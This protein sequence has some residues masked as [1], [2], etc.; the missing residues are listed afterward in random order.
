MGPKERKHFGTGRADVN[1]KYYNNHKELKIKIY[2]ATEFS[3]NHFPV[4]FQLSDWE[5]NL[6]TQTNKRLG[7]SINKNLRT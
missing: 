3:S 7:W 4:F 6:A 1:I 2:T 5:E